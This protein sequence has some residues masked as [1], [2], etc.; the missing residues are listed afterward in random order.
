MRA[1]IQRVE[2][3]KVSVKHQAISSIGKGIVIFL[4]VEKGDHHEEAD[5][6]LEKIIHLRIFEDADGKMNRSL[7]DIDGELLVVSQFTLLADCRK[8]RRP[9]FIKAELPE[10]AKELYDYF[11]RQGAEKV[12]KIAGGEFQTMMAV[13]LVNDGPVTLIID[14]KNHF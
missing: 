2:S 3:A 4:G 8:G 5:H 12:K 9:S 14:N 13:E 6:L 10:R 11:L 7:I 1:V